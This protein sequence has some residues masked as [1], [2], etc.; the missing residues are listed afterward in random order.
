MCVN[1]LRGTV[2]LCKGCDC[3]PANIQRVPDDVQQ[4]GVRVHQLMG[5]HVGTKSSLGE[6][7]DETCK[8]GSQR[9]D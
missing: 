4:I 1:H 6:G 3:S 7:E 9:T 2:P 8:Q 5:G